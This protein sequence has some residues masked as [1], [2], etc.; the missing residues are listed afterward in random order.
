MFKKVLLFLSAFLS[1]SL[2]QAQNEGPPNFPAKVSISGN[3][4]TINYDGQDILTA[5]VSHSQDLYYFREIKDEVNG[6]INHSF[7]LTAANSKAITIQGTVTA[8]NQSFPCEENRNIGTTWIRH[9]FGLSNSLLN[10]AVYDRKRDWSL[11]VEQANVLIVPLNQTPEQNVFSIKITGSEICILFKPHYYQKHRGLT[12]FEPWNY[13]VWKKPV[14]GWCSWYAYFRKVTENDVQQISDVL[15]GKLRS[16]GL[17]YI[18][19]DDGYQQE[20]SYPEKWLN[21]NQQFPSGM[22]AMASYISSKGLKPGIWTNVTFEN[23]EYAYSHKSLFVTDEQGNPSWGRWV[24][25][26]MDGSN[27]ATLEQLIKPVY[28][29][30]SDAGW[31]YY[32]LDALRH[33]M[34]EGY[35]SNSLYFENK[36]ADRVEAFRN[37]VKAVRNE[38][39]KDNFLLACWG[40][41]PELIGVVDGCRIGDDG[42]GL[43][44]LTQYNSFNNVVWRNDPDHIELKDKVAFPACMVTSMTGSLFML[45]DKPEVY[46]TPVI[47][48]AKRSIPVLFTMPGQ[49]YDIDPSCSMYIDRVSSQLSGSGPR[50]F[51]ARYASPYTH[52]LLEI[53][54]PY[55]NWLLLGRTDESR[56]SFSF[57]ELGLDPGKEYHVFE[58]WTKKY[59]GMFRSSFDPVPIDPYYNCQLLCIREKQDHPQ[60]LATSRHISCGGLELNELSWSEKS[61]QGKSTLV[62]MDDYSIYLYE[63]EGYDLKTFICTGTEVLS[64]KREGTIRTITIRS[65]ADCDVN[66]TAEYE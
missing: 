57:S 44:T 62:G 43:R 2:I 22:K 25:Y 55:E 9:S 19:I 37:V 24:R 41:R 5:T 26:I 56:K 64:N 3:Q 35:N 45:T 63:P 12:Y 47:E 66:W 7:T 28:K 20:M 49:V 36:K 39:G 13:D 50:I 60:L 1:V 4:L 16:Y 30:F 23:K 14:V 29:G 58:F 52:F 53:N 46:E 65:K 15:S 18:Q 42:F 6:C 11:S 40:I 33:L 31:K 32:K 59:H 21:W 54:K 51:D 34:Y 10:K 61:L 48:A 27:P 8:S 38:T 17:G